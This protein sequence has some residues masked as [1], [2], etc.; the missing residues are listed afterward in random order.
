M[1]QKR[2]CYLSARCLALS[3]AAAGSAT[4]KRSAR[5]LRFSAI[6]LAAAAASGIGMGVLPLP[7]G[8]AAAPTALPPSAPGFGAAAAVEKV[9]GCAAARQVERAAACVH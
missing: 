3:A 9:M 8:S 5:A 6:C 7:A 2:G 1:W 4:P